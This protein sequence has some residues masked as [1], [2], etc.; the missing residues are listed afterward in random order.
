MEDIHEL[1]V[2]VKNADND[3]FRQLF[4]HYVKKVYGIIFSH[5]K[6]KADAEDLTQNVFIRIW[7]NR[8]SLDPQKSFDGY[9][10]T[11]AYNLVIDHYRERKRITGNVFL[12]LDETDMQFS[13]HTAEDSINR[14]QL[15]SLYQTAIDA[16]PPKRKEIFILSRHDGLSNKRIAEI[17]QISVKTVEN[18]MTAALKTIKEIFNKAEFVFFLIIF[19]FF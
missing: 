17:L 3:A 14:H 1:L 5:L 16:L 7:N 2:R 15:D 8:S 4:K 12:E 19:N 9:L 13:P 11:I 18:Q 10:Y 6:N